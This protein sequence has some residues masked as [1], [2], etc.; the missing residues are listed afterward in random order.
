MPKKEEEMYDT[1]KALLFFLALFNS[2]RGSGEQCFRIRKQILIEHEETT[3]EY[4]ATMYKEIERQRSQG[5]IRN[6]TS[7]LILESLS[8]MSNGWCKPDLEKENTRQ[9]RSLALAI[10]ALVS[11]GT[12]ILGPAI[13]A[14]LNEITE[15]TKWRKDAAHKGIKTIEWMEDMEK[16]LVASQKVSSKNKL[17]EKY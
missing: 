4:I 7:K 5:E 1:A 12:F 15:N 14:L 9:E 10:A 3:L 11:L 17:L 16:K 13:A 6:S 2:N 8:R